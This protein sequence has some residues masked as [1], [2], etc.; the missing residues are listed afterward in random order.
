MAKAGSSRRI[1][2]EDAVNYM[3]ETDDSDIDSC[4][5]GLS[6]DEE[7][8]IDNA[9]LG[10]YSDWD[11][12]DPNAD[13]ESNL[14][15]R[16]SPPPSSPPPPLSTNST[17]TLN[18]ES[19]VTALN[20]AVSLTFC[21]NN[22][23]PDHATVTNEPS[24]RIS[25]R[26]RRP[27]KQ[28]IDLG[29][30]DDDCDNKENICE[31]HTSTKKGKKKPANKK[32]ANKKPANKEPV[33][34]KNTKS[35]DDPDTP[36]ILPD[37]TPTRDPGLHCD[38]P[39]IRGVQE[40]DFFQLFFSEEL[41]QD[42]VKHTN[43]Y[44]WR[45][46][47]KK[48]SCAKKDGS[49]KETS[50]HEMKQFIALLMY[51]GIVRLPRHDRYW[52]VKSLFHGL[53][54][55][56]MLSRSRFYALLS[57]LH[58]VDPE[59]E[60]QGHK[61]KKVAPFIDHFRNRCRTLF[62]PEQ[63]LAVDE[64]LVKSKHRSGIRQYIKN[65]PVKFGIKLWVIADS[66]T[67]YTCDFSVYMGSGDGVVHP[68]HGLGYGVV[69]TLAESFLNQ[70]YH[71]FF[72][73]FYTS[74]ILVIDLLKHQ[75]PS[76]G[77]VVESRKG[78]PDS[79]KG[80]KKSWA[81]KQ[82]RGAMRWSREDKALCLQWKDNKVVTMVSTIDRADKFVEVQRKVKADG[83]FSTVTV[84]QPEC[85]QRYNSYM[86]GVDKSDQYLAKYNMLRKCVRWWKTLF[87]HMID[88]GLVNGFILFQ[89]H[90][91]RNP[92]VPGLKRPKSYALLVFREAVIR[93]LT[94]MEEY[95]D[96]P[97][98]NNFQ[99]PIDKRYNT[100]HMPVFTEEKRN[101]KVCYAELKKQVRV[102]TKCSA[103]Q[104]D[105]YL[106]FTKENNCFQKWHTTFKH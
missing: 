11:E 70:G 36:N 92:D 15:G 40:I 69:M 61:L 95:A 38:V 101:C 79:M 60:E 59:E 35:Y 56:E 12:N 89:L 46:I 80:G 7:E 5:G 9:L 91:S 58:V 68:K 3:L 86:N 85:I 94:S 31:K 22:N 52:S 23:V 25:R 106:H 55:R 78:F 49:W 84:R 44:G 67:G 37:F 34:H 66:K 8:R 18:N 82:H 19:Q 16:S 32:P 102:Y 41:I 50:V 30:T 14:V 27:L 47:S 72:D 71:I 4:H 93:Q 6:S 81:P 65:K 51:M 98:Y 87:F 20:S 99:A 39:L 97:V 63:N 24:T 88:V 13:V 90:R 62:Q 29:S 64:R 74:C 42:I 83:K 43:T 33:A 73:N 100:E 45:N 53:W 17:E 103:P 76:C 77:T 21:A 105:V 1:S 96:P 28:V 104:C 2:L 48:K 10:Y 26:T 54:A 57:M 75:T